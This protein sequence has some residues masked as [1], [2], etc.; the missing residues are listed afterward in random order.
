MSVTTL[1]T[2]QS[3]IRPSS[4]GPTSFTAVVSQP[5]IYVFDL[6]RNGEHA[7]GGLVEAPSPT[8]A[9]RTVEM[10]LAGGAE[11]RIRG[12]ISPRRNTRSAA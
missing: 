3:S 5:L 9:V 1:R 11:V 8:S 7:G 4:S 6:F 2:N 12:F 10:T